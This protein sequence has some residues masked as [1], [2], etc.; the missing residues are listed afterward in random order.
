MSTPCR[1]RAELGLHWH[2]RCSSSFFP[3]K[4]LT[5]I[6]SHRALLHP[7]P[8]TPELGMELRW[9]GTASHSPSAA[10]AFLCLAPQSCW[11]C[12][13]CSSGP[14]PN[15]HTVSKTYNVILAH[16]MVWHSL[17]CPASELSATNYTSS[18]LS[19]PGSSTP[20]LEQ[21]ICYLMQRNSR[22]FVN[23]LLL[24]LHACSSSWEFILGPSQWLKA[25]AIW[26]L[27]GG[28]HEIMNGISPADGSY[29]VTNQHWFLAGHGAEGPSLK[30]VVWTVSEKEKFACIC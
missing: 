29:L 8:C 9:K 27:R 3:R 11:V 17:R 2:F 14:I 1:R 30:W 6:S 20:F 26:M 19:T 13:T 28:L 16:T 12:R 18:A 21:Y 22:G 23:V 10:Q 15:L 5:S 7:S 4:P 25:T 24:F